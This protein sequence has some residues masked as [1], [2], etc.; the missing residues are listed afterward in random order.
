MIELCYKERKNIR[1]VGNYSWQLPVIEKAVSGIKKE[2]KEVK[3]T[4]ERAE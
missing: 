4:A 3:A 1:S 2:L